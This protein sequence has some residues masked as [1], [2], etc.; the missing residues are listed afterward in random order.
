MMTKVT[1]ESI[2]IGPAIDYHFAAFHMQ[3]SFSI[4]EGLIPAPPMDSKIRRCL[5]PFYKMA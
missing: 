1:T 2:L 3:L 4:L 5:T